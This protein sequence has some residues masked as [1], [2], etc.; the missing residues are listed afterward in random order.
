[1]TMATVTRSTALFPAVLALLL[2]AAPAWAQ[3]LLDGTYEGMN[4]AEG[5]VIRIEPDPGGFTG[6]F[7][8][9][10]GSEQRFEADR[11]GDQ[12]E[13]VLDLAAGA[14]LMQMTPLP[15]G[16]EVVFIPFRPDGTLDLDRATLRTFLREGLSLPERPEGYVEAPLDA[17][18]LIAA[19]S[20]L[21]SYEFWRPAGVV[22]G[23]L[24]LAPRHRTLMRLFPA[25]QLDVIWKLCLAPKADR[26]LALALD[27]QG[28]SCD[29]VIAGI[30]AAQ[31]SGRF[32][33]YKEEVAEAR[34]AMRVQ[35]RCADGYVMAPGVCERSARTVAEAA[36]SLDTAASVLDRY[37]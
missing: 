5:A 35:V 37:R 8:G 15:Y 32:D 16:A 17:R 21:A 14:V 36:V 18:E 20:F 12:A 33:A 23:Y 3:I 4:E 13:T 22:N 2:A 6:T 34:E 1:M 29:E 30:A 9:T 26:A 11:R 25:V 28:V 24:S 19:N 27:G 31:G 7:R 10:D